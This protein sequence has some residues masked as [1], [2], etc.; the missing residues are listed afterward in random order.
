LRMLKNFLHL[1]P[2]K[3]MDHRHPELVSKEVKR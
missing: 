1:I 2:S 3:L